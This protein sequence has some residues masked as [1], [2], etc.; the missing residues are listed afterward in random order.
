MIRRRLV[1]AACGLAGT[2]AAHALASL[3]PTYAGQD[4]PVALCTTDSDCAPR[5]GGSGAP[6]LMPR[7]VAYGCEGASGPLYAVEESDLP[8]CEAVEA[9]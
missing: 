9:F 7:L 8:R 3:A 4:A 6:V 1:A 5:F 2:M